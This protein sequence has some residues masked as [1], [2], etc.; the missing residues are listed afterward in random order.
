[1]GMI[2]CFQH[3]KPDWTKQYN[4]GN[5]AVI[6]KGQTALFHVFSMSNF[7]GYMMALCMPQEPF[8]TLEMSVTSSLS[9]Y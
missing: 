9:T 7:S 4:L 5:S 1:M 2:Y 3:L 8:S 6:E